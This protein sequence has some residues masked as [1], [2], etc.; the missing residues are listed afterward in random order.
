MQCCCSLRLGVSMHD[1]VRLLLRR[2]AHP[3]S[4]RSPPPSLALGFLRSVQAAR[5]S[6]G[7]SWHP[8]GPQ[9]RPL[10]PLRSFSSLPSPSPFPKRSSTSSKSA[11]ALP[12]Q[13]ACMPGCAPLSARAV[14]H[15]PRGG[16]RSPPFRRPSHEDRR[17][18]RRRTCRASAS[19]V[20][21]PSVARLFQR[22]P[23][24]LALVCASADR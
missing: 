11:R 10:A 9:P 5:A 8:L 24:E 23:V 4:M 2:S 7:A 20:P 15:P 12:V 17:P 14:T 19:S 22:V 18:G 6:E 13:V 1:R 3:R 16:A 21:S